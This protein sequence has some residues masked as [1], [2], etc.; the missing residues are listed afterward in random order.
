M[1]VIVF[2]LSCAQSAE[3]CSSTDDVCLLQLKP[4]AGLPLDA[5]FVKAQNDTVSFFS[6]DSNTGTEEG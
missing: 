5:E 2:A 6:S 1:L 4:D 3:R